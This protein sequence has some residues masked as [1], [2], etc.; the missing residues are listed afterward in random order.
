MTTAATTGTDVP[1][2]L[3]A[4]RQLFLLGA[5]Q[6][7]AMA[8]WFAA[9]A[10]APALREAWSLS[11]MQATLLTSAVQIGFVVGALASALATLADLVDPPRLVAIGSLAAAV[12]T[13]AV[14]LVAHGFVTAFALRLVSGMALALVYPVG[15]MIAVSW[16]ADRRGLAVGVLVGALTVGST[17]PH[18][19]GGALG[20]NWRPVL[21][22][23]AVMAMLA[24][25]LLRWVRVGP[26]VARATAFRPGT[27]IAIAR[28]RAPRLAILGYLGHMWE[29]YAVWAWLPAFLAAGFLAHGSPVAPGMV[30]AL[31][32]VALGAFGALGCVL[33]GWLGDRLGRARAAQAA[34]VTSGV[35]CLLAAVTFGASPW[36]VV[37]IVMVWGA[38][39]IADSAMFS[40]CL[41]SVV[42]PARTG[43]ALT[44][45][46]A[47]GFLVTIVT[48]QLV[49]IIAAR[50]GWP[51]AVAMLAVG[52]LLG[53]L[54][55]HRLGPLLPAPAVRSLPPA[56]SAHPKET[57]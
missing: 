15:M 40:A 37:P 27:V 57:P 19:V 11:S 29:L 46:T 4:R 12:S 3:V 47:L 35:C 34:M 25:G 24:A 16:F 1:D 26:L 23:A 20:P 5:V 44:V 43:T 31:S 53:A 41:G 45:Q 10:V 38:A 54:A 48:I 30:G 2:G 7:L 8:T 56:R 55:M 13:A 14:A 21:L 6:I 42:E 50:Q 28:E 22:T 36:V 39:V 49:P 17:L 18:L 51:A 33:S 32:F 9:S 52:P